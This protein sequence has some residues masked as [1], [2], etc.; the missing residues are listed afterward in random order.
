MA[1]WGGCYDEGRAK[2]ATVL[3]KYGFWLW[4]CDAPTGRWRCDAATLPAAGRC[5]DAFNAQATLRRCCRFDPAM[6]SFAQVRRGALDAATLRSRS[7][8]VGGAALRRWQE[9]RC[10]SVGAA[11]LPASRLAHCLDTLHCVYI[12]HDALPC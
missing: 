7:G 5:C 11:T 3:A 4:R 2:A 10:D 12:A 1:T 9:R 8:A 6:L